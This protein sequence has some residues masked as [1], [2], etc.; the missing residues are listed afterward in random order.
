MSKRDIKAK[1]W[2]F[3]KIYR[4]LNIETQGWPRGKLPALELAARLIPLGNRCTHRRL[5]LQLAKKF[6]DRDFVMSFQAQC[7]QLG[8]RS[9]FEISLS[10]HVTA[11]SGN[12][13][14]GL[15][16]NGNMREVK[17]KPAPNRYTS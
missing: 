6:N 5:A 1:R 8:K 12:A 11:A 15:V 10:E 4:A 7:R 2:M 3:K 17:T 9:M 13:G 16:L 14:D